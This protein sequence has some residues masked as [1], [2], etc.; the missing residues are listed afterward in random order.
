MDRKIFGAKF[1][2]VREDD[3]VEYFIFPNID[4]PAS[5]EESNDSE[6]TEAIKQQLLQ[7]KE[8]CLRFVSAIIESTQYIWHK[9]DFQLIERVATKEEHLLYDD[10]DFENEVTRHA[11]GSKANRKKAG[12]VGKGNNHFSLV[13]N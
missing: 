10:F 8:K 2:F 3:Y 7:Y 13:M 12:N 11:S 4:V 6:Q 1:E 9:D 5:S